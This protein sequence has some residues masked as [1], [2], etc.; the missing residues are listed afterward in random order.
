MTAS[1]PV[2]ES[3]LKLIHEVTT[4]RGLIVAGPA[5]AADQEAYAQHVYRLAEA[6]GWPILA[7]GLSPARHHVPIGVT[8]VSHYDLILRHAGLA[9]DLTPRY[10][11]GLES[12]PTSKVL[13][14]W[15][16]QCQAEMLMVSP[17]ESNGDAVHGRTREIT[18]PIQA[19]AFRGRASPDRSYV[20]A[21]AQAQDRATTALAE[22]M[23][24]AEVAA[25]E[26]RAAWNLGQSNLTERALVVASSMPVRDWEYFCSPA[27]RS[28]R[29]YG[30]RGANGIDG[31][32]STALGVARATQR[33]TVLLT[34]DLAF[35]H[36]SNGLMLARQ[37]AV[38]LTI[39]VINNA[40]GGI[41]EHLPIA[42]FR[43]EFERLFA[44]PSEVDLGALCAAH[45]V[46]HQEVSL[47]TFATNVEEL[48]TGSGVRVLEINT[49][50]KADAAMRKR[51]FRMLAQQL[52]EP[53]SN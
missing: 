19:L 50:R 51:G 18:S 11:L 4:A 37:A 33:P 20:E 45:G 40:G 28:L 2:A 42:Q 24:S 31:T 52:G 1:A 44:T 49:D 39:L 9:R 36:D 30:N 22:W 34:G 8:V 35:V 6:T 43:D 29:V 47:N 27:D 41:F 17:R 26:G 48:T 32:I 46:A 5:Y 15:L 25:F 10:V 7:D 13:R 53:V 14:E 23:A 16:G 21:W 12:W 3:G 38:D